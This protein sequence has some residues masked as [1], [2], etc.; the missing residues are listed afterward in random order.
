MM[1]SSVVADMDLW[2]KSYP[3]WLGGGILT[4]LLVKL[5]NLVLTGAGAL[6][7]YGYAI[8]DWHRLAVFIGISLLILPLL[9]HRGLIHTPEFAVVLSFGLLSVVHHQSEWIACLAIGFIVGW[10]THLVT[11]CFGSEGIHSQLFPKLKVALQLFHN[12]GSSERLIS[13]ICWVGSVLMWLMIAIHIPT[14]SPVTW[15][16]L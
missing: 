1:K 6:L 7:L 14:V 12:G 2:L 3:I 10:W 13:K 15:K 8:Y 16:L 9:S 4:L 5:R 11:D